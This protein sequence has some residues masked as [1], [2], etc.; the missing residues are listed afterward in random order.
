MATRNSSTLPSRAQSRPRRRPAQHS[1]RYLLSHGPLLARVTRND[2]AARYAGSVLGLGW[3]IVAPALFLSIYAVIY[4]FIYRISQPGLSRWQYV[5]FI[6]AGLVP[7]L[8]TAEAIGTGVTAV[9]ANR[10]VLSNVVFPI[11]LLAP[12]AVLMALPTMVVGMALTV[13]GAI[14]AGVASWYLLLVPVIAVLQ[15]LALLGVTWILSLV[16]IV[17]R[18]LTHAIGIL[19][20]LLLVASP[21]AYTTDMVPARLQFILAIN[22]LA[23]F[24]IA[25]QKVIV[26]GEL[27]SPLVMLGTVVFSLGSFALGGWF[28]SRMK[29][30]LIDYV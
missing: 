2:L 23:Y 11:D 12:K 14:A 8:V 10:S 3:T 25:Y 30:G 27:P 22:P 17:L 18:D 6:M 1:G 20:I 16:N 21:I 26:L 15:V 19:L 29:A 9:V 24:I 28:F 5:I 13:V 4:L 7:Y